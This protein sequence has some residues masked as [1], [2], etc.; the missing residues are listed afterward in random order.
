VQDAQKSHGADVEVVVGLADGA[1]S[2]ADHVAE[3]SSNNCGGS[4]A[5]IPSPCSV[6]PDL[7]EWLCCEPIAITSEGPQRQAV[8]PGGICAK[9]GP[10]G[11]MFTLVEKPQIAEP[12]HSQKICWF[13]KLY[14][15]YYF[16]ILQSTFR[17]KFE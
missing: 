12:G 14:L 17:R 3:A 7:A 11:Y 16:V 6:E 1:V 13:R 15:S 2:N 5:C 10:R 9:N 4:G 8:S